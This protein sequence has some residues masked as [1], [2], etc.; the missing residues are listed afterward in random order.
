MQNSTYHVT[1]MLQL[2]KYTIIRGNLLLTGLILRADAAVLEDASEDVSVLRVLVPANT[3][4]IIHT[5]I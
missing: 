2:T 4:A 3:I 1:Y 5:S